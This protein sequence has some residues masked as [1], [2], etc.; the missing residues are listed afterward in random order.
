MMLSDMKGDGPSTSLYL[1][2]THCSVSFTAPSLSSLLRVRW[3]WS[4]LS[5]VKMEEWEGQENKKHA[6]VWR[7]HLMHLWS[8]T[9][10]HSRCYHGNWWGRAKAPQFL[11]C[12]QLVHRPSVP[13]PRMY[14]LWPEGSLR[15][16]A[17]TFSTSC[18][19]LCFKELF[20]HRVPQYQCI[21]CW[22]V[23]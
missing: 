22:Q 23:I 8:I 9:G 5:L 3:R 16:D 2:H 6:T 11:S 21:H 4:P 18:A 20:C 17:W 19:R 12:V 13:P 7:K 14:P 10:S 15:R 1:P